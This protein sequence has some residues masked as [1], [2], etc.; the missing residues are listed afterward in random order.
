VDTPTRLWHAGCSKILSAPPPRGSSSLIRYDW[1]LRLF[2]LLAACD[3]AA[4]GGSEF[5]TA[6]PEG[7]DEISVE[8][9]AADSTLADVF[10][11]VIPPSASGNEES[12]CATEGAI[13][14]RCRE[15]E[16]C[17]QADLNNCVAFGD[18]L[19]DA[20]KAA[21]KTCEDQL[22]CGSFAQYST[23]PCVTAQLRN[24]SP[25]QAQMAAQTAYCTACP[26]STADC[27]NFF[28]VSTDGGAN[29]PGYVLLLLSDAVAAKTSQ[30]CSGGL[31]CNAALYGYCAYQRFCAGTG[32]DACD[33]GLCP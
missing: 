26:N 21:L 3:L 31:N 32:P 6:S 13:L 12:F 16:R 18:G 10:A 28:H 33:G 27:S 5:T 17:R 15:C 23:D 4:C 30:Q 25:T 20:F 1:L 9:G 8:G 7:G 24:T 2:V 22:A 11:C 14:N 29:G 19:S